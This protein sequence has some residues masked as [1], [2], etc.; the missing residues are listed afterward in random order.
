MQALQLEMIW[1]NK[2]LNISLHHEDNNP[3]DKTFITKWL[4]R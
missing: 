4:I 3:I 2:I 1:K